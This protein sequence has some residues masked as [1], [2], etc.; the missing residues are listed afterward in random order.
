[1]RFLLPPRH[2]QPT[3]ELLEAMPLA[4]SASRA[5]TKLVHLPKAAYARFAEDEYDLVAH[6]ATCH[7][8]GTPVVD[9]HGM[10]TLKDPD[11][12]AE[13]HSHHDTLLN[14]RVEVAGATYEQHACDILD[15]LKSSTMELS[16][17]QAE[18]YDALYDAITETVAGGQQHP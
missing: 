13:F 5:R 2:L 4:A 15:F 7:D 18:A 1:M 17:C 10:F 14:T 12:A 3:L 8:D 16:G 11:T 6:Y 9:S